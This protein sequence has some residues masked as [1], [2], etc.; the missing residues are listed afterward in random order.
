MKST[1]NF[2]KIR[3]IQRNVDGFT[4][5]WKIFLSKQKFFVN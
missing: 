3:G 4:V 2:E 5:H 1:E